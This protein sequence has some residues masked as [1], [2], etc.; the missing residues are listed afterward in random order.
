MYYRTEHN[1]CKK[2]PFDEN[3][4]YSDVYEG[5]RLPFERNVLTYNIR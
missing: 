3:T 4:L 5:I 2:L 1:M